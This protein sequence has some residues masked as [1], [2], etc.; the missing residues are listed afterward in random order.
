[1]KKNLFI[2]FLFLM[3]F[4]CNGKQEKTQQTV[5][6]KGQLVDQG[7]QNVRMAYSG[8]ASMVGNSRNIVLNTDEEGYFD[9]VLVITEPTFY[10]ISR[11]TLYL[12][13]GDD[14]EIKIGR[15]PQDA[16]FSGVGAEA[17][18]YMKGR[19]FPKGGSFLE[20]GRQVK[21]NF[22]ATKV[23]ID[24][25]AAIRM[26]QLDTLSNVSDQ[27]KKMEMARIKGDVANSYISYFTYARMMRKLDPEMEDREVFLSTMS[28][29]LKPLLTD[30]NDPEYLNV[31]VVRDVFYYTSDSLHNAAWFS[32]MT[33]PQRTH[34]LYTASKQANKLSSRVDEE[35]INEAKDL[36]ASLQNKDFAE[37]IDHKVKMASVLLPGQPAIDFELT[38]VDGDV[39]RLSDFKGKYIYVDLWATWC[40][41]CIQESPAFEALG[42]KL[43]G[44]D[45]VFLPI[46]T[47][48]DKKVWHDYLD[49]NKKELA[50]YHST[51]KML[52]E[53]W[54]IKFIPRF[55]LIDK[56]FKI[57]D[58]YASRPSGEDTEEQLKTLVAGPDVVAATP[59]TPM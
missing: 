28:N 51:D 13:P 57:V 34:E 58:A 29:H 50:Q 26:H 59:I 44:E 54:D 49:K 47:D 32:G 19:L 46:S 42:Q 31:A 37:E 48:A 27:F 23:T 12:T 4:A 8:A 56:D 43:K 3:L 21:D 18:N 6:L 35:S 30:L 7:T 11:N 45:I 33:I 10:D 22:E 5:H 55:L 38:T 52:S 41:P 24:S 53:G 14:M 40:G 2:P 15:N 16:E 25:L 20:A 39:K 1:M 9:T 36:A 17:N